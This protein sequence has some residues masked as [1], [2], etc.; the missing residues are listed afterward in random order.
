MNSKLPSSRFQVSN[1]QYCDYLNAVASVEDRY[2]VYD[3]SMGENSNI[4]GIKRTAVDGGKG[5]LYTVVDNQG[6][7]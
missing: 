1:G 3:T 2:T 6:D 4:A 7:S 5:F